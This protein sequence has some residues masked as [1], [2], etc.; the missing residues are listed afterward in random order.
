MFAKLI[1]QTLTLTE[2]TVVS[3]NA[4]L[5]TSILSFNFEFSLVMDHTLLDVMV[6]VPLQQKGSSQHYGDIYIWIHDVYS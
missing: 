3:M 4:F 2:V 6:R 5:A 1:V